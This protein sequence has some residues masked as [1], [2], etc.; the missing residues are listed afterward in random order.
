VTIRAVVDTNVVV[1]G[2]LSPGGR[3]ARVLRAAGVAYR[4]VWSP[5]V[6]AECL[7]VLTYPRVAKVLGAARREEYARRIVIGLAAGA[8][9][10]SPEMLPRLRVV[11]ADPDDD[12]FLATALAGGA[13]VV[14]SGDRR[15]LLPLREFAGVRIIGPADFLVELGLTDVA[16]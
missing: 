8:D 14:V 10:V 15:H 4:L 6:V 7:R 2:L 9:M 3:P 11:E 5:G 13:S 12:L 1:S 16:K